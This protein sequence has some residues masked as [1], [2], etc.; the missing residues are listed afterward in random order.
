L[1]TALKSSTL[2]IS[3]F[4]NSISPLKSDDF[5]RCFFVLIRPFQFLSDLGGKK[6]S[7]P[8]YKFTNL[9]L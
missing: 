3:F 7:P 5:Y 8:L 6:L 4:F 1:D 2:K 9:Y